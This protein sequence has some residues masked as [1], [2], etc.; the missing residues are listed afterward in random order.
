MGLVSFIVDILRTRVGAFY[1]LFHAL[2]KTNQT[3]AVEILESSSLIEIL[4]ST[5]SVNGVER[6]L[7]D[8][9]PA[10]TNLNIKKL[11]DNPKIKEDN[12]LISIRYSDS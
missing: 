2:R 7:Q 9:F 12:L 10:P 8:C 1:G 3:K 6:K 5:L 11:L 4:N